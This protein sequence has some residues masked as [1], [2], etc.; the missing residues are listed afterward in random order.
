MILLRACFVIGLCFCCGVS[1]FAVFSV[2]VVLMWP[3]G[4]VLYCGLLCFACVSGFEFVVT[5]VLSL[6]LYDCFLTL[7]DLCKLG[8]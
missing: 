1:L 7:G 4:W 8:C 3:S 5:D 2:L 6:V